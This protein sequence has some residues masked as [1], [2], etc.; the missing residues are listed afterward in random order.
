MRVLLLIISLTVFAAVQASAI[1]EPPIPPASQPKKEMSSPV[2]VCSSS[3]EPS[4]E[5]LTCPDVDTAQVLQELKALRK[6][7]NELKELVK[8]NS[9]W[10]YRD[11]LG[12]G[13]TSGK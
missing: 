12:Q 3:P 13:E 1:A 8:Q 2:P 7:I 9:L 4:K 10:I 11:E 6:Q 5:I